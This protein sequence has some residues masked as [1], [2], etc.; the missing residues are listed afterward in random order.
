MASPSYEEEER[1]IRLE[2]VE[3]LQEQIQYLR[4]EQENMSTSQT[5]DLVRDMC[6]KAGDF[7]TELSDVWGRNNSAVAAPPILIETVLEDEL[8]KIG[9]DFHANRV[10]M[11]GTC[12]AGF[13]KPPS[14]TQVLNVLTAVCAR[15][16]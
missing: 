5:S 13:A 2:C 6:Q 4:R 8:G 15:L 10:Q 16:K 9:W 11:V 3:Y 12:C 1:R 14:P 7:A